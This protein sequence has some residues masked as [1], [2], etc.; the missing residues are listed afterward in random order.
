MLREWCGKYE[1]E[2]RVREDILR[3][4]EGAGRNYVG[5]GRVRELRF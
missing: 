2:W 5:A 3:C 1:G 4:G